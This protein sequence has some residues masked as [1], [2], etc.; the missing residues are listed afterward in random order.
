[1]HYILSSANIC[2][3]PVLPENA[4]EIIK[5][6]HNE[7][8]RRISTLFTP[9]L[10]LTEPRVDVLEQMLKDNKDT[11]IMYRH[12]IANKSGE[13]PYIGLYNI[14]RN[15]GRGY[16]LYLGT[17]TDLEQKKLYEPLKLLCSRAFEEWR[18][19]RLYMV[20]QTADKATLTMLK[21]FGF[22]ESILLEGYSIWKGD[23]IDA[24]MLVCNK[25]NYRSFNTYE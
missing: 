1:M 20:V 11:C 25:K 13:G 24:I 8:V 10:N 22:K 19:D 4:R 5:Y 12:E 21:G 17:E 7:N 9:E 23:T 2:L 15:Q 3:I 6:A 16:I 18:L 14:D